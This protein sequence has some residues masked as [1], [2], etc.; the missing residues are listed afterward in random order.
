[1]KLNYTQRLFLWVSVIFAVFSTGIL[2]FEH[3]HEKSLLTESLTNKLE[4]YTE[5][6]NAGMIHSEETDSQATERLLPLF[7][8]NLRVTLI[9]EKGKVIVDNSVDDVTTLTNHTDRPEIRQ[10]ATQSYGTDIR[11]SVSNRQN[12]LYYAKRFGDRYIRVALPY[13]IQTRNVLAP[14]NLFFYFILVLF[15]VMLF[16]LYK[17]TH[18]FGHSIRQLHAFARL[19]PSDTP[20]SFRFPDDELGEIGQRITANYRELCAKSREIDLE[21]ER[22]LQHVHSSEEGICFFSADRRVEFF[23]GLFIQYLNLITDDSGGDPTAIFSDVLFRSMTDFLA[24]GSEPYFDMQL[25]KQ[26]RTFSLRV[27]RFEDRR[28]E[29]ILND[30]TRREKTRKLKQELTGN[31]AHELRT[32]VAAIRGYLETVIEQPLSKEQRQHFLKQAYDRSMALSELI[33][34]IGLI[35][36]LDEGAASFTREA[37][38]MNK[39]LHTIKQDLSADLEAHGIRMRWKFPDSLTIIG[40]PRLLYSIFRNL[41]DNSIRYAG[42]G[43]QI[44]IQLCNEDEHHYYFSFSDTGVG[45]AD[46]KHL[47][48]LFERFYRISEGRTRDTGGSGLGLSIVKNAVAFHRGTITAKNRK[49]GGLEFLFQLHK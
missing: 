48:R 31:I 45:I 22:L 34:D 44:N 41:T 28:F 35:G 32:P 2:L 30:V 19:K 40:N 37:V 47:S 5:I 3:S 38:D 17:V 14:D 42:D 46:E 9:D 1:M 13:S 29:I 10:A 12:Y 36:K 15:A 24:Q 4:A 18:R 6:I 16:I 49:G 20:P 11:T 33:D 25:R 8:Q 27:N 39:L 43:V 26:G 23:N 7:P 21:R